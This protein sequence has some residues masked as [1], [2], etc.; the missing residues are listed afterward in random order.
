M[1]AATPTHAARRRHRPAQ[2]VPIPAAMATP[3]ARAGEPRGGGTENWRYR[4]NGNSWWYWSDNNRWLYWQNDRW[5]EYSTV[6]SQVDNS[7]PY[8]WYEGRWWYL[9]TESHWLYW[10][11]NQWVASN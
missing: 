4:Q 8:R 2:A 9:T 7:S 1:F 11:D 5:N 10:D 3:T 6:D